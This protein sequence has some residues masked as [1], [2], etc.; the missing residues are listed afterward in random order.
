MSKPE[1]TSVPKAKPKLKRSWRKAVLQCIVECGNITQSCE[2]SGVSV[3]HFYEVRKRDPEFENEVQ[4]AIM[5][6]TQRLEQE[7]FK[8]AKAGSDKLIEFILSRRDPR[9]KGKEELNIGQ[10]GP[11][12]INITFEKV[13]THPDSTEPSD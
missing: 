11:M 8:R 13:S 5:M 6:A 3:G 12:T 7:A 1:D 2:A 4:E 10:K 9:Y